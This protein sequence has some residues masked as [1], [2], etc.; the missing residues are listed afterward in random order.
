MAYSIQE[1]YSRDLD[2]YFVDGN[3][4]PIHVATGGGKLPGIVEENDELN[5]R[6]HAQI[7]QLPIK[8][9]IEI[10][11][12][13]NELVEFDNDES[14]ELYLTDFI[15]MAGKGFI[16]IDKT[17]L[18]IFEDGIYHLV[19]YPTGSIIDNT[20]DLNFSE[21]ISNEIIVDTMQRQSFD[22]LKLFENR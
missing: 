2:W 17:N 4:K 5:E 10:N 14:R 13:L 9:E 18:G 15:E 6:I 16:S 8:Y 21:F 20:I 3:N 7:L 1:Q 19:A 12:I 22:L 11:P